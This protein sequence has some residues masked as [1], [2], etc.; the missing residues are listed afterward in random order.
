MFLSNLALFL[1]LELLAFML[2]PVHIQHIKQTLQPWHLRAL[3][4][5][6]VLR[7]H[8]AHFTRPVIGLGLH[9]PFWIDYFANYLSDDSETL[10]V[11]GIGFIALQNPPELFD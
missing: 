10:C 6:L 11:N 4:A 1:L 7:I 8:Q 5:E 3:D 2:Q 9:D